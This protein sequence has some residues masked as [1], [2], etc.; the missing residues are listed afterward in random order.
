MR[1]IR[2]RGDNSSSSSNSNNICLQRG[3][4]GKE[5]RE[6]VRGGDGFGHHRQ[7]PLSPSP[8]YLFFILPSLVLLVQ[9]LLIDKE[10]EL[11]PLP[12]HHFNI[13][14]NCPSSSIKFMGKGIG[15]KT[16]S[17]VYAKTF[18]DYLGRCRRSRR[19]RRRSRRSR[20]RRLHDREEEKN[21]K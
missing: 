8:S 2:G 7:H 13:H 16:W 11:M 17:T 4:G 19:R 12:L 5:G 18:R 3:G 1:C 9:R 14:K 6:G 20:R 10:V 15:R 21:T